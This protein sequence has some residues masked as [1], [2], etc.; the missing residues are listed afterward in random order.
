M[1]GSAMRSGTYTRSVDMH[2][3]PALENAPPPAP[4]AARSRSASSHTIIG[5][6]PPSSSV[7][8]ISARPQASAILRPVLTEP[9]NAILSQPASTSAAPV[10]PSPVSGWNTPSGRPASARSLASAW[11]TNGVISLGFST[12]AFPAISACTVGFSASTNGKFQGVMTPTTPIGRQDSTSF[13][14]LSRCRPWLRSR[15][16]LRA[17]LA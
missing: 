12:T 3:W 10:A 4:R 15:S 1:N 9:V 8:G 14:V 7:H 17:R 16:S 13:L 2:T 6:L 5:S 11:P